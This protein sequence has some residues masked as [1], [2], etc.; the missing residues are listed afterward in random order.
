MNLKVDVCDDLKYVNLYD[1]R[2]FRKMKMDEAILDYGMLGVCKIKSEYFYIVNLHSVV[3]VANDDVVEAILSKYGFVFYKKCVDLTYNGYVNI[4]KI[5]YGSFWD[6][7]SWIGTSMNR[8]S[9]LQ[10]HAK[11][12]MG[13]FPLRAFVFVCDDLA[14]V[15]KKAKQ[16]IREV[17][18]IGNFSVHI[19]DTH[20]EAVWLAEAYFNKNSLALT[21]HQPFFVEDVAFNE[22]IENFKTY[23][24]SVN[25][26]VDDVCG[27]GSTPLNVASL[28]HSDDFDY[29][30]VDSRCAISD[31]VYSPHDE[32][33]SN[34]PYSKEEIIT[35]PDYHFYYQ[36]D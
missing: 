14:L 20:E 25:V 13:K 7:E 31:E 35:N 18:N 30:S 22:R 3:D 34:Y 16:E 8:F 1:Y 19:N 28:R 26:S 32:Q 17:F 36:V 12:S 5:S 27:A 24:T 15:I 4:K 23:L 2:F 9:G 33:L 11:C 21:N 29:L 10:G 6:R